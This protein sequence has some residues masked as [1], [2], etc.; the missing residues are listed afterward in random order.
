MHIR[1]CL[2]VEIVKLLGN[3][4]IDNW[5]N[6]ALLVWTFCQKTLYLNIE[7]IHHKTF[8]IIHQSNVF[9]HN[10]LGCKLRFLLTEI[11]ISNVSTNPRF[12]WSF[13]RERELLCN[14]RKGSV[15][16]LSP[17]ISTTHGKNSV[18]SRVTQI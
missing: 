16:F 11:C 1:K 7:K 14:Q 9:Y 12:E 8:R 5:F 17:A 18:H 13:F 2:N 3:A 10:L 4:L 6:C 15:L